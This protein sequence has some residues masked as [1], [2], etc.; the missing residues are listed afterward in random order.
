L[1]AAIFSRTEGTSVGKGEAVDIFRIRKAAGGAV[2]DDSKIAA[3]SRD[4]EAVLTGQTTVDALLAAR[5]VSSS[6]FERSRPEVPSTEVKVDN[7]ISRDFTVLD[8]FTQDRPGVLYTIAR[9]LHEQSLDIHWSKVATE[10][11]RVAD[12]FYVRDKATGAKVL[13]AGRIDELRA[14]LL[15]ALPGPQ[16]R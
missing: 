1:D 11:D 6:L 3:I 2:T 5:P 8:V 7:D 16:S 12:I 4:L 10:A 9:V 14:A 13:D 15:S